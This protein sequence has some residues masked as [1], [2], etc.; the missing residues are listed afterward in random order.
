MS[1]LAGGPS[2]GLSP[3]MGKKVSCQEE[4]RENPLKHKVIFEEDGGLRNVWQL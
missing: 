4:K 3:M 2:S 1:E